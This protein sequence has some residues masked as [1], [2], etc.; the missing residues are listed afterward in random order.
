MTTELLAY[1]M[2]DDSSRLSSLIRHGKED[3]AV[4]LEKL[5]TVLHPVI[6]IPGEESQGEG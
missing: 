1:V 4:Y 5:E 6:D 3:L 2:V